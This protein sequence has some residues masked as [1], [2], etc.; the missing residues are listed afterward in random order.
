MM[1]P[2]RIERTESR[3]PIPLTKRFLQKIWDQI[4][5]KKLKYVFKPLTA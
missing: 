2:R 5:A 4:L 3:D 1:I